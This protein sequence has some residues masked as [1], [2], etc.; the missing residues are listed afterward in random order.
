[1]MFFVKLL[2]AVAFIVVTTIVFA[3][4]IMATGSPTVGF[5]L[6]IGTFFV[7]LL[8]YLHIIKQ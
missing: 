8:T 1:M 7:C 2:G 5:L 6:V 4:I 3:S